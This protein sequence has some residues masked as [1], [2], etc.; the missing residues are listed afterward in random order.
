MREDIYH[1]NDIK[2]V[3][4]YSDDELNFLPDSGK[5]FAPPE[6]VDFNPKETEKKKPT[7]KPVFPTSTPKAPTK[8]A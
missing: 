2:P 8:P 7:S 6:L 1:R 4:P 5:M 3:F